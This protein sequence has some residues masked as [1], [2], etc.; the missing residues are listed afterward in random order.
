[1]LQKIKQ[2]PTEMIMFIRTSITLTLL[3]SSF[4]AFGVDGYQ[5]IK[6][7]ISL[8]QLQ[9]QKKCSISDQTDSP[10]NPMKTWS[11]PDFKFSD[12]TIT[13][14]FYFINDKLLRIALVVGST[15]EDFIAFGTAL[16]SKFG[17]PSR[18][19]PK[20]ERDNYDHHKTNVLD[21][22]FDKNTVILR[23]AREGNHEITMVIYNSEKFFDELTK[24]KTKGLQNAL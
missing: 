12:K 9:A 18:V 4:A 20:A 23:Q 5:D 8:K 1:M 15:A 14:H 6:F 2:R 10:K 13:A 24:S 19:P 16:K 7:N 22:G 21:I 11:C 17:A 3:L